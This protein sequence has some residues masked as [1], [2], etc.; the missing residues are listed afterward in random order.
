M[1]AEHHP[2]LELAQAPSSKRWELAAY[3]LHM[4]TVLKLG[5][6]CYEL[7]Y[8]CVVVDHVLWQSV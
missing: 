1:K 3:G 5:S 4:T 8:A 2:T 7:L 6:S